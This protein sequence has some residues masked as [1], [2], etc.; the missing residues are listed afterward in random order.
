MAGPTPRRNR[1]QHIPTRTGEDMGAREPSGPRP[2][3]GPE[4][5]APLPEEE[6]DERGRQDKREEKRPVERE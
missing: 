2:Q 5:T 3:P 4:R 1:D 6:T